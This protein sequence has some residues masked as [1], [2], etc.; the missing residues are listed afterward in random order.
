MRLLNVNRRENFM[1]PSSQYLRL[2]PPALEPG[3][4]ADQG[5]NLPKRGRLLLRLTHGNR[6]THSHPVLPSSQFL[7]S[8]LALEMEF[9]D[10]QLLG[11]FLPYCVR[12]FLRRCRRERPAQPKPLRLFLASEMSDLQ[13]LDR[14]PNLF[15]LPLQLS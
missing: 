3:D 4:L 2:F 14:G 11:Q 15:F 6:R 7:R 8:F 5:E 1:L 9:G 12:P 10:L 13:L